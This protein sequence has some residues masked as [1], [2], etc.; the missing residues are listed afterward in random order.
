MLQARLVLDE[1][2][3]CGVRCVAGLPDNASATLISLLEKAP[4]IRYVRVTREGEAFAVASGFWM[5]GGEAAVLVQNTGFLESGDSLR[6]TAQRMRAPLVLLVTYR[7]FNKM[8]RMG[9]TKSESD[10]RRTD[11]ARQGQVGGSDRAEDPRCGPDAGAESGSASETFGPAV[12]DPDLFSDKAMDSAAFVTE[13]TLR[14]WG[15]PFDFLCSDEDLPKIARAFAKA[16]AE[17]RPVALL[18]TTGM[19]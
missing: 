19:C 10:I 12:L 15:I 8:P 18:V 17:S 14:A 3:A 6:G 4:D 1:L 7:G 5:G 2:K 11:A 13:P 9:S 16:H